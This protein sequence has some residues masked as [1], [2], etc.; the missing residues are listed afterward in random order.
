[1]KKSLP[2]VVGATRMTHHLI[3][4]LPRFL[5]RLVDSAACRSLLEERLRARE[6]NFLRLIDSAV[7]PFPDSPYYGLLKEAGC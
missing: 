6:K 5:L 3:F 7:Y 1:M 2:L 4:G